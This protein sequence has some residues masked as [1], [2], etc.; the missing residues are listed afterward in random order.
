MRPGVGGIVINDWDP[1]MYLGEIEK[2]VLGAEQ[3]I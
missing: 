2:H 3:D 1:G